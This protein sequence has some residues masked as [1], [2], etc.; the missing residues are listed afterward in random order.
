M[1]QCL[2]VVV[3]AMCRR[4]GLID[5]TGKSL[6]L[7]T[8]EDSV[9]LRHSLVSAGWQHSRGEVLSRESQQLMTMTTFLEYR[10]CK[11]SSTSYQKV[12][13]NYRQYSRLSYK[14]YPEKGILST[15][16]YIFGIPDLICRKIEGIRHNSLER[17][18]A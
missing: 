16:T 13:N 7:T 15:M 5:D 8:L 11:T 9:L 1:P 17:H 12:Q 18:S 4:A 6:L 3:S 14:A 2:K 10:G